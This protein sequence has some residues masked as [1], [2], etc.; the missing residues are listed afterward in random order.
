[1]IGIGSWRIRGLKY[2]PLKRGQFLAQYRR[3]DVIAHG[4]YLG[5]FIH[6][7]YSKQPLLA[8]KMIHDVVAEPY[9]EKLLPKFSQARKYALEAGAIASGISGSGPTMFS[10]CTNLDVAQRLAKWLT[11]NYVQN[12]QG[13]VHV[14]QLDKQGAKVTGSEL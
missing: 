5:G 6:A 4:R 3:Q 14:C 8:A 9:R 13:F 7:C 12:D 11:D 2:R 1:M 10:I